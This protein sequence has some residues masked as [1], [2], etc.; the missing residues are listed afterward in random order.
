MTEVKQIT[1]KLPRIKLLITSGT[2]TWM[3]TIH[4]VGQLPR[5]GQSVSI[6][7]FFYRTSY[8]QMLSFSP[9]Y[10]HKE[11]F[12]IVILGSSGNVQAHSDWDAEINKTAGN[13][14]RS[15]TPFNANSSYG[16]TGG[17]KIQGE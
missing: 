10:I 8:C 9:V 15:S 3:L 11:T 13:H 4:V 12:V 1:E 16:L 7:R 17:K 5:L 14:R 2:G 6:S